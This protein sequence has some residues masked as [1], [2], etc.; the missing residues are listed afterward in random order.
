MSASPLIRESPSMSELW[1]LNTME[2]RYSVPPST[3]SEPRPPISRPNPGSALL[4]ASED[5]HA[6]SIYRQNL[7]SDFTDSALGSQEKAPPPFG[8]FQLRES[9]VHSI[10]NNPRYGPKSELGSNMFTYLK[11]GLPRVFPPSARGREG[12]SGYDSS[13]DGGGGGGGGGGGRV[14][15]IGGG[16][17]GGVGG[18]VSPLGRGD[19]YT[20]SKSNPDLLAARDWNPPPSARDT[21]TKSSSEANLLSSDGFYRDRRSV[22]PL[23]KMGGSQMSLVSRQSRRSRQHG[24][25]FN[26][27]PEATGYREPP[28]LNDKLFPRDNPWP[29][30]MGVGGGMGF[31]GPHLQVRGLVYETRGQGG[32]THLLDGISVEARGGEVLAIMA[33]NENEGSCLLDVLA[34]RHRKW[35]GRL[36]G[37]FILNGNNIKPSKVASRAAYVQQDVNFCQDMSVRQTLLLHSFFRSSGH[38][39]RVR[40]VKARIN[41]LIND[42]GLEQVRH[43]R[44]KDLTLSERRRLNVACGLLLETDLVLL[45]Q[46][47]RGMDIFDTFFLVEYLRQWAGRGRIVILT[48]QPPTYEIFTMISRVAL[49][50]TGRLM[51]FGKRREM[52]PYFAFI[53]YPC[54]AYKNPSDYYLDLVTLD[55]LS[56]EAMLESSQRVEML[57]ETF[58]RRQEALSD[59]GSPGPLPEEVRKENLC[60]QLLGLWIRAMIFQFPYNMVHWLLM[61]LVAGA[62]SLAIGCVFWDVR[63]MASSGGVASSGST[64]TGSIPQQ[65]EGVNNRAGFHYAMAGLGPWPVLLMA[66]SEVWRDRP[67]V[68]RD[69]EDGLYSRGVYIV[70]KTCYSFLAAGGA[71]LAYVLPAYTMAGLPAAPADAEASYAPVGLTLLY[72][73]AVRAVAVATACLFEARHT[74]AMATGLVLTVATVGAGFTV[75]PLDM[76]LW[77]WPTLWWSPTRWLFHEANRYEFNTTTSEFLCDRNPVLQDTFSVIQRKAPCGIVTGSQALRYLGLPEGSLSQPHHPALIIL[78]AYLLGQAV[79]ILA[80]VLCRKS[81]RT[82][83][84]RTE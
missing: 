52:L 19:R 30:D 45:D 10:L 57:A 12:S 28:M 24:A 63:A 75:H 65:Q 50:S 16:V 22:R 84:Y 4:T 21:R 71:F 55:D 81:N 48:I 69:V 6:W 14:G 66:I 58:R 59:P 25:I 40:E 9:T 11:F 49:I 46:P 7:N 76:S 36:R 64:S 5:L 34:D 53:E 33:T 70:T 82:K 79:T 83:K 32:R 29:D 43:T 13:D 8:N 74:A 60:M 18:G 56:A 77:T 3:I 80:F 72:L 47:T 26:Q 38:V 73:Y 62:T 31:K 27:P 35:G 39:G 37:D 1:E 61:A 68:A 2:R 67:A 78:G 41:G 23:S 42:L 51:Y 17:V 15:V 20:R 54:P 44:V